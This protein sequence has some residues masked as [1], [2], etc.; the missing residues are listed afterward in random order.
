M[1]ERP[2]QGGAA[3]HTPEPGLQERNPAQGVAEIRGGTASA[4]GPQAGRLQGSDTGGAQ[5]VQVGGSGGAGG[6]VQQRGERGLARHG[7]DPF[8]MIQQ[9]SDEMDQLFDSFFYGRPVTR[10]R[11]QAQLQNVWAPEVEVSEDGNQLRICVDLPGISKENVKVDIHEGMLTVQGERREER[12][13]GGQQ[14]GFRRSERRYGSFYRSIALPEAAD[15]EQAQASMKEGVLEITIP[16][17]PA[18][19]AR[20]LEIQG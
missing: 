14:Q 5:Q 4:S 20:R 13:E 3:G 16:L 18:K 17:A 9:L 10:Q 1:A 7:T 2:E 19:Q 15:A 8:A 12:T 6:G 11:R